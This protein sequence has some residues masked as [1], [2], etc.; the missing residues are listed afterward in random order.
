MV[1]KNLNMNFIILF[2]IIKSTE[3]YLITLD[4]IYP[5]SEKFLQLEAI[6]IRNYMKYSLESAC[7]MQSWQAFV[8]PF[9]FDKYPSEI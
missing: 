3:S 7:N 9:S 8:A 4:Q 2:I 6:T 1:F 5:L